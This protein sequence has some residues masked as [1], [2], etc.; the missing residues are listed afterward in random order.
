MAMRRR[1]SAAGLFPTL[2]NHGGGL[3]R[4]TMVGAVA[5]TVL[6]AAGCQAPASGGPPSA[7]SA[8][9]TSPG[10]G[11]S[12]DERYQA[13]V[14]RA[15]ADEPA[16]PRRSSITL[17]STEAVHPG[18]SP[19]ALREASQSDPMAAYRALLDPD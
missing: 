9:R 18:M 15:R 7:P 6:A 1:W 5:A 4:G 12:Y 16:P 11:A 2:G 13:A 14:A 10:P 3:A 17:R 19:E 8:R